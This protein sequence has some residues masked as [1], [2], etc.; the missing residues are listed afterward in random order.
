MC[1]TVVDFGNVIEMR[2]LYTRQQR[3]LIP[4]LRTLALIFATFSF[5][6]SWSRWTG[7]PNENLDLLCAAASIILCFGAEYE[8]R[9]TFQQWMEKMPKVPRIAGD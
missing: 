3:K 2:A 9:I 1:E 7:K 4:M 8:S 5:V 6:L